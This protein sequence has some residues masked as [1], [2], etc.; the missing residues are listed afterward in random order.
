MT[1]LEMEQKE[2]E[3]CCWRMELNGVT[4]SEKL[5]NGME[6]VR[7]A[8][9]TIRNR[10]V[11]RPI[12]NGKNVPERQKYRERLIPDE[13]FSAFVLSQYFSKIRIFLWNKESLFDSSVSY[14]VVSKH[15]IC[16]G[17]CVP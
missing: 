14:Y 13:L 2:D 6:T 8:S 5:V 16:S 1:G 7:P 15:A 10:T 11:S 12:A 3:Q 17:K 4:V 9:Y